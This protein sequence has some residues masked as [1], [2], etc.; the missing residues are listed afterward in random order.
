MT[1]A[2]KTWALVF[3]VL[4][5]LLVGIIAAWNRAASSDDDTNKYVQCHGAMGYC[6]FVE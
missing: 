3:V 5:V 6:S 1:E 4:A 2:K